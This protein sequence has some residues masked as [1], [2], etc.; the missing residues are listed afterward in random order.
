[1]F[2]SVLELFKIGSISG[3][4]IFINTSGIGIIADNISLGAD[5]IKAGDKIIISGTLADHGMTILT[6]RNK[7]SFENALQ[8]DTASLA[9]LVQTML[10]AAPNLHALRDPTRGGVAMT[11]NEFA[12]QT[13][14]G[15][16]ILEDTLPINDS[17]RGAC[18]ILGI[19]PLYVANEGKLLAVVAEDEADSLLAAM[20]SHP[21]GKQAA[22]IGEVDEKNP[23]LV[24][25][26][27]SLGASRVVDIPVAEQLPRI[28]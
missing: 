12:G 5:K 22:I 21:T 1:M 10:Q 25:L 28:C 8:S 13:G 23:G 20:R 19:D 17:V 15:F 6:T 24:T 16:N 9:D 14:L 4:K 7:L 11:L 2:I 18:E 26:T 27:T 3:D